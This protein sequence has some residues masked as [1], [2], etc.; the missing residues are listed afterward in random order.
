[1][2]QEA[3]V[4]QFFITAI[5]PNRRKT[6]MTRK[7]FC[8]PLQRRLFKARLRAWRNTSA[9]MVKKQTNMTIILRSFVPLHWLEIYH[10]WGCVTATTWSAHHIGHS[11]A[12]SQIKTKADHDTISTGNRKIGNFTWRATLMA[13]CT[14]S[15]I[16]HC[17][18]QSL[19]FNS[20]AVSGIH[21]M[22]Y[23][24]GWERFQIN[25]GCTWWHW[26]LWLCHQD[27]QQDS[28]VDYY[29]TLLVESLHPSINI[30]L[31]IHLTGLSTRMCYL[32]KS[33]P[34]RVQKV[35]TVRNMKDQSLDIPMNSSLCWYTSLSTTSQ[36]LFCWLCL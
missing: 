30:L 13:L 21:W 12:S 5:H 25:W 16:C 28:P 31:D 11:A 15:K 3:K 35:Q 6:I 27:L 36:E 8:F 32:Y 10:K 19:G 17:V 14:C 20:L 29:P 26:A 9:G 1:M 4:C 18:T 22:Y 23:G 7:Q 24:Q 33:W 34:S 2:H